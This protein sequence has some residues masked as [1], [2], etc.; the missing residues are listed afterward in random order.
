MELIH[1]FWPKNFKIKN[2]F[3]IDGTVLTEVDA[4]PN[5][6]RRVTRYVVGGRDHLCLGTCWPPRGHVMRMPLTRAW[7]ENTGRDV[8]AEAK[9]VDGPSWL[10][11]STWVPL[12]PKVRF[13][14]GFHSGG[15]QFKIDFFKRFFLKE[16]GPVMFEFSPSLVPGKT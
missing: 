10:V 11:A 16:E 7:V 14:W 2:I 1:I 6:T 3:E 9:R 13:S 15:F 12:W 8:T 4:V 5:G